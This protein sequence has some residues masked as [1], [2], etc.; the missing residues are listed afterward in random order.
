MPH[1]CIKNGLP[2][3]EAKFTSESVA[4]WILPAFPEQTSSPR[5]ELGFFRM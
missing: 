1:N 5:N 2:C 4:L 3:G